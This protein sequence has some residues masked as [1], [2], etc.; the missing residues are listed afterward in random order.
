M[1]LAGDI[2]RYIRTNIVKRNICIYITYFFTLL[3]TEKEMTGWV[4]SSKSFTNDRLDLNTIQESL[5]TRK[6]FCFAVR[7]LQDIFISFWNLISYNKIGLVLLNSPFV[8][9]VHHWVSHLSY[10]SLSRAVNRVRLSKKHRY[11][12]FKLSILIHIL[13]CCYYYLFTFC[14][15]YLDL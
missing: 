6:G 5:Y 12:L 1:I 14:S 13:C 8:Q 15:G 7:R 3:L 9:N 2:T 4:Y 10:C 11:L